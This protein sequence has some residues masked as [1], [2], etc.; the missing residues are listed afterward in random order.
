[1]LAGQPIPFFGDGSTRRDYTYVGDI[2]SGLRAAMRYDRTPFEIVNLGNN[3]AVSLMELVRELEGVL[4]ITAVIDRQ[5]EQP[6]DVSQTWANIDKAR[7]LLGYEPATPF[8][9][10][11]RHFADWMGC[12]CSTPS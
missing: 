6:G 7:R 11:L 3:H 5:P 12:Q 2:V 1:M 10:G 8:A 4:G 9:D